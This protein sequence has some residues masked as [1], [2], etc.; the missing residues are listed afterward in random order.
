MS[1]PR[2]PAQVAAYVEAGDERSLRAALC[3]LLEPDEWTNE[4]DRVVGVCGIVD[5]FARLLDPRAAGHGYLAAGLGPRLDELD[6]AS[7]L[8][9]GA[10]RG[11]RFVIPGDEEWPERLDLLPRPPYGLWVRGE[12]HLAELTDRSVAV[13]GS[14][15]SSAYGERTAGQL[16]AGLAL[17]GW[18]VVSGGAYGIDAA[19]H[20]A[21]LAVPTPTVAVL[22]S[23]VDVP[24]PVAHTSLIERIAAEGLVVSE[25]PP[26]DAPRQL[27]FLARNRI[28]AALTRGTV[29]VE[30]GPRSGTATT[31]RQAGSLGRAVMVVPGPV[32][33]WASRGCHELLRKHPDY[34]LVASAEHVV[35]EV[36]LIGIDLAP[37]VRGPARTRDGLK[38]NTRRVLDA[39]PSM[40]AIP[41]GRLVV[42]AG[43]DE[44]AV[45]LAL[46][47]LQ[48]MGLV[49]STPAGVRLSAS[50]RAR[51]CAPREGAWGTIGG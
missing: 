46:R 43:M 27:R 38:I 3:R 7:D 48:R 4:V 49:E 35:E 6:V 41:P 33:A 10:A 11:A 36:G 16:T 20:R 22:A 29:V 24:Y 45:A 2:G 30:A 21:A 5:A 8:G 12:H 39:V 9:R 19:A 40:T 34:R 44:Q 25:Q 50:E 26:G 32:D 28:V 14:R 23:G 51:R 1:R 42:S 15:A 17:R 31:A 47:D 18:T 13:I 37:E